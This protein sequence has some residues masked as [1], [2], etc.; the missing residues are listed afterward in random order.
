MNTPLFEL[1][2]VSYTYEDG[3]EA[4]QKI[5]LQIVQ[6]K[7]IA[8]LGSNGAGKSTL[9][10]HLNGLLK[11]TS[12]TIYFKGQPLSY[13]KKELLNVR[14][15]VGIVFQNPE[16]QLFNGTVWDDIAYGPFNLHLAEQE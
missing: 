7:K 5:N 15:K 14:R 9:I 11:P 13:S 12:G 10:L 1:K 6:G 2:E 3:T 16:T 4:L 8:L